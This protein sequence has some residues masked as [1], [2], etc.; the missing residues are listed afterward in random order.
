MKAKWGSCNPDKGLIWLN[1]DL[2][3]KPIAC[4]EYV[5]LHE[6]THFISPKLDDTFIAAID[7]FMPRW[8]QVRS[9]LNALPLTAFEGWWSVDPFCL[10]SLGV[11]A[12]AL[13][14]NGAPITPR[15][16]GSTASDRRSG[17]A[18]GR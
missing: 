15:R 11:S 18:C 17:L 1:I 9:E 3:K 16:R 8:R 4:F 6:K 12:C 14:V 2:A 13:D 10:H 5:T 7:R